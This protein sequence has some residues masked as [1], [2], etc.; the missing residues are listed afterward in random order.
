ML[1]KFCIGIWC[2]Q[3]PIFSLH[4]ARQRLNDHP[5]APHLVPCISSRHHQARC[6]CAGESERAADIST[7][8]AGLHAKLRKLARSGNVQEDM[9]ITLAADTT[10]H[11]STAM[12]LQRTLAQVSDKSAQFFYDTGRTYFTHSPAVKNGRS[13]IANL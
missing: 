9:I 8:L 4:P 7:E 11:H 1:Y 13:F 5:N 10:E 6:V 2:F 3:Q 12:R